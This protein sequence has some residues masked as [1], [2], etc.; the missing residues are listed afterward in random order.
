[1]D[2]YIINV[3]DHAVGVVFKSYNVPTPKRMIEDLS[4]GKNYSITVFSVA[5]N[6]RKSEE[7]DPVIVSTSKL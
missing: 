5:R 3:Y 4:P 1:M 7:S 2:G 6:G